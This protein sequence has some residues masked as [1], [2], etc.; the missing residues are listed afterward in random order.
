MKLA[1][2]SPEE[3]RHVAGLRNLSEFR[4]LIGRLRASLNSVDTRN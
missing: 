2:L 1:G 4:R 3:H